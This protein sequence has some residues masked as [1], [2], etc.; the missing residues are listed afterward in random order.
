M[1]TGGVRP[2]HLAVHQYAGVV[3]ETIL[4]V[5]PALESQGNAGLALQVQLG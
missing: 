3:E 2:D 1:N 4:D 5:Q